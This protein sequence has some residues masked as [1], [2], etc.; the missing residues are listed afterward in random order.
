MAQYQER[1]EEAESN[2][3]FPHRWWPSFIFPQEVFSISKVSGISTIRWT[4]GLINRSLGSSEFPSYWACE[5][6]L[7]GLQHQ[8]EISLLHSNATGTS[9]QMQLWRS[10]GGPLTRSIDFQC[11]LF[12]NS[13]EI[14]LNR[15]LTFS[16]ARAIC[17]QSDGVSYTI[18]EQSIIHFQRTQFRL[19]GN[20]QKGG[21]KS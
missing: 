21:S 20:L 14:K 8:Q 4:E 7:F 18:P 15:D 5:V 13:E 19:T 10:N 11:K 17:E 16:E 9:V 1:R 12:Q 6:V 2:R 3:D